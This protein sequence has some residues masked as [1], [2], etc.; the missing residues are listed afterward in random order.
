[1]SKG[2]T[3]ENDLMKFFFNLTAMPS[4]GANLYLALHTTDPGEGGTQS[5]NEVTTGE[6]AGYQ[7]IP[8]ARDAGGWTVSGNQAKNTAL[9]QF[10]QCTGGTGAT[11]RYISIGTQFS[12]A[13]Q[14]IYSGILDA[15][16][17]ISNIIQP[18]FAGKSVV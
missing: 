16:I 7:R 10:P 5:T 2:D 13:G 15:P 12:G 11:V 17:N 6:Y 3:T 8:V 18:Q 14:I 9:L 1:M 4:Y